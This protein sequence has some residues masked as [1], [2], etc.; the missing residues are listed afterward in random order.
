MAGNWQGSALILSLYKDGKE[1][2]KFSFTQS[3][4]GKQMIREADLPGGRKLREIYDRQ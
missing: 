2:M 4:D 1:L 3:A